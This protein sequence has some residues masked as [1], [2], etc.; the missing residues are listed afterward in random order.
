VATGGQ[1]L[2][3]AAGW[4]MVYAALVN[5]GT[6]MAARWVF[7]GGSALALALGLVG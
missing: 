5:L 4:W 2:N 3:E 6:V 7:N 1:A